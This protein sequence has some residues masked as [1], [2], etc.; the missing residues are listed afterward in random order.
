MPTRHVPIVV[1]LAIYMAAVLVG[2]TLVFLVQPM[3]ARLLLPH[4]G[5]SPAVWATSILFFQAA[6]L[7]GYGWAHLSTTR[8]GLR[9]QPVFQIGLVLVPLIVL[10]IALPAWAT[11]PAGS[12]PAA[13]LLLVLAAMVGLPYVAVTTASPVLQR[14]FSR[15]SHPQAADP[16]FLYAMGNAGS[17]IGL[18]AYPLVIEP[19]LTLRDQA[20]LWSVGYVAF[21]GLTVAAALVLRLTSAPE[22]VPSAPGAA[23]SDARRSSSPPVDDSPR[24]TRRRRLGWVAMAFVPASLMLGVTTYISAD[25]AAVPLLWVLPLSMYLITFMIAFSPRNPLTAPRLAAFLP[26]VVVALAITLVGAVALPL[27]VLVALNLGAFFVAAL[28]AHVRLAADRPSV[29]HLTEFYL[30]LAVGG[31][32]AGLFNALVA[33]AIFDNI[34]EYPLAITLALL[35]RP[36]RPA[37]DSG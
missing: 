1:I 23:P 27:I 2:A 33:P 19:N 18:L 12:E 6:L 8:L 17:L 5:G 11:P 20:A 16:Y 36:G 28:L 26:F 21:V 10:P 37:A 35:L 7:V 24:P 14:W 22:A 32:L 13:W 34:L 3:A 29:R 15:T 25:L 31:A 30:L 4:F 9:R